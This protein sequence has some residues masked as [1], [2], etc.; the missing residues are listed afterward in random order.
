M[1][2]PTT[3]LLDLSLQT[4]QS[5]VQATIS[6]NSTASYQLEPY[7]TS[8]W[9]FAPQDTPGATQA[10]YTH[11]STVHAPWKPI[12]THIDGAAYL[13]SDVVPTLE[14]SAVEYTVKDVYVY[15]GYDAHGDSTPGVPRKPE[16]LPG[17]VVIEATFDMQSVQVGF[18]TFVL[19][20]WIVSEFFEAMDPQASAHYEWK[21]P[22]GWLVKHTLSTQRYDNRQW[23]RRAQWILHGV[24]QMTGLDKA[25]ITVKITTPDNPR[26]FAKEKN[27]Q[28]VLQTTVVTSMVMVFETIVST[29]RAHLPPTLKV[30]PSYS[31]TP[32]R[33][34]TGQVGTRASPR[35]LINTP[36]SDLGNCANGASSIP[37]VVP[38]ATDDD[39]VVYPSYELHFA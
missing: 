30:L 3:E 33:L 21:L 36:P 13:N 14:G 19:N 7:S 16:T 1:T 17:S 27:K 22:V 8:H 38:Q 12:V 5:I 25:V 26:F 39:W 9:Q 20:T 23:D 2:T 29:I 15:G 28:R 4:N 10:G 11:G 37:L 34:L 35:S 31:S 18:C 6:S 32:L 24:M